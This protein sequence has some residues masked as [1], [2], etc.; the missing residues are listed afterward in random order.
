LR[1]DRPAPRLLLALLLLAAGCRQDMHDQPRYEPLETSDFFP[2]GRASRPLVEG[3]VARGQLREDSALYEGRTEGALVRT[4]P[5]PIT[6]ELLARGRQRYDIYC[7]PCHDRLGTGGGVVV[8]RGFRRPQ[9]FH[10]FRL[11]RIAPGH[12][13][14]AMTNGFGVMPDYREQIPIADRWAIVAYIKALQYSQSARLQDVPEAER[15]PLTAAPPEG[16]AAPGAGQTPPQ[17][18]D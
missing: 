12:F 5:V 4:I 18:Q 1:T 15:G 8:Q 11:R 13:F 2:D 7:S 14:A 6:R 10:S 3:T 9:S 17:G 16:P